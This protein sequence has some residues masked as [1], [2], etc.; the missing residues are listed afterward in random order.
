MIA[1]TSIQLTPSAAARVRGSTEMQH[2]CEPMHAS[3]IGASAVVPTCL[4]FMLLRH[5]LAKTVQRKRLQNPVIDLARS[6]RRQ[7]AALHSDYLLQD[8]RST[9][10]RKQKNKQ[11][12]MAA[13][14]HSLPPTKRTFSLR[15]SAAAFSNSPAF[16]RLVLLWTRLRS[17]CSSLLRRVCRVLAV[18][19]CRLFCIVCSSSRFSL[20]HTRL[21]VAIAC[22]R[23]CS[24]A[25]ATALCSAATAYK[26]PTTPHHT[27]PY[28]HDT[29]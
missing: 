6:S 11:A 29:T 26:P 20:S 24:A 17:T 18:R 2:V 25:A 22:L 8:L 16:C 10:A 23:F 27:A 4:L 14:M 9:H 19:S 15:K 13:C 21:A 3:G 1:W 28:T 7:A 5:A 12:S